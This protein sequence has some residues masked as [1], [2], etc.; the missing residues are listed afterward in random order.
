[1]KKAETISAWEKEQKPAA[2][3]EAVAKTS[4]NGAF[5]HVCC[6]GYAFDQEPAQTV[7]WPLGLKDET[8]AL[9]Y[10]ATFLSTT[11]RVPTIVGHNVAGF[12]IRFLWQRAMVL[13]VKMPAWFPRDPKPWGNEVFD[14]MTAFAGAREYISMDNLSAALGLPGK[15]EIDGSMIGQMFFE[16]KHQEIAD[17]CRQDVER[18]RAIHRKMMIALGEAA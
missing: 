3:E 2:I 14:T 9:R 12:D 6:V 7:S 4:L 13:G 8:E 18:T 5:G 1:M 15:G 10:L 16:G 11:N 17:Y